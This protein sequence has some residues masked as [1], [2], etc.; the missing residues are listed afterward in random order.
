M[1]KIA[2]LSLHLGYGGIEKS[3]VALAN[4]LCKK[5]QVEI[6]TTYKL[7]DEPVFDVNK[8]VS[9]KYLITDYTPNREDFKRAVEDKKIN[10]IFK[11]GFKSVK[12]LHLRKKTMVDYIKN[13]DADIVISTRDIFD[14]W[15]GLYAPK[16]VIKIGWEHNHY[17]ENLKYADNVTRCAS[18]LDY[19]VLVSK[20]L[21]KYYKS[22]LKKTKCKCVY[23]PNVL[24]SVPDKLSNLESK[25]IISVGR[26]SEEKGYDDLLKIFSVISKK[27]DDW[28]LDIV[29]EGNERKSLER[30][31]KQHNLENKVILHG[32]R[33][34]EYIDEL[35]DRSSIYV[36]TSHTESFGI[37]LIEAM[38]HGLPCI[39]FSSAEGARELISSGKNGYLIKNRSY[40]A[41]IKKIN[42]LIKDKSIRKRIGK[43][44]FKSIDK[45]TS[46]VVGQQWIDLIEKGD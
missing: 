37:V 3:I 26:L 34:K 41:I 22:R 13:T 27:H 14:E 24:D 2:I 40:N 30:Y 10:R 42:D 11:E 7:Y 31:I 38:S 36:M 29:G 16:N 45:Y 17:H 1:K 32:F 21:Q 23:I 15:L 8:K 46:E 4:I 12:I 44:A 19:L 18:K 28:V 9:I 20:S 39:A 6:I 35:M 25:R 5:Y 43:S 33:G